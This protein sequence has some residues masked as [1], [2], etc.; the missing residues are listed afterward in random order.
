MEDLS[1]ASN[2]LQNANFLAP[3]EPFLKVGTKIP[4]KYAKIREKSGEENTVF[5]F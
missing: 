5:N 2:L 1:S 3:L 4:E